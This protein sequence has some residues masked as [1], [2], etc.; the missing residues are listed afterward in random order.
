MLFVSTCLL[1]CCVL[2]CVVLPLRPSTG[3]PASTSPAGPPLRRTAP[4][5][6]RPKFRS[7]FS[8][9]RRIFVLFLFWGES[10]RGSL[11]VFEAPGPSNVHVWALGLSCEA[12]AASGPPGLHMTTREH[13]TCTFEGPG[14][15]KT[16]PKFN[17]KTPKERGKER[18][19]GQNHDGQKKDWRKL[20]KSGWPKRD[21]QKSVSS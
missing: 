18:K 11:V 10:S 17:E 19:F 12:P 3:P 14:L 7:L 13:Q 5:L 21:W 8:L 16:P 15:Q 6:D 9:S 2:L 1:C 4:P 20:A